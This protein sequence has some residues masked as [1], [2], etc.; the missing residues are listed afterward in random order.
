[1]PAM[2]AGA[3]SNDAMGMNHASGQPMGMDAFD[4]DLGFDEASLM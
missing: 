3:P 1:M 2:N 4:P